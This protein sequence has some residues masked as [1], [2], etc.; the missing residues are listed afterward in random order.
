MPGV[1][2][3]TKD[4]R[5]RGA[6]ICKNLVVSILCVYDWIS[7]LIVSELN[8]DKMSQICIIAPQTCIDL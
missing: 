2:S 8:M 1:R 6:N 5:S 7:D 3:L 4:R